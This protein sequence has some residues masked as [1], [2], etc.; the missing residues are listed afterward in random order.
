MLKTKA[1]DL[2]WPALAIRSDGRPTLTIR[3]EA[4]NITLSKEQIQEAISDYIEEKLCLDS[5]IFSVQ[6]EN[7]EFEM[8]CN[9]EVLAYESFHCSVDLET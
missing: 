4:M 9:E 8:V 6:A 3:N 1:E 2:Q 5:T 7:V